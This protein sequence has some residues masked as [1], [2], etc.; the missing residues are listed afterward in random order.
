MFYRVLI[1]V[2]LSL[3]LLFA[4]SQKQAVNNNQYSQDLLF[5]PT[6]NIDS[7]LNTATRQLQA[8]E[9]KGDEL[10]KAKALS[11]IAFANKYKGQPDSA[12][13][14]Y[15][16]A[17]SIF[18]AGKNDEAAEYTDI[19]LANI[20]IGQYKIDTALSYLIGVDSL[21]KV[22]K[23]ASL[24]ADVKWNLGLVYKNKE[25]YLNAAR[26]FKMALNAFQFQKKYSKYILAG[27][28]LSMAYRL[29][30][31]NDSSLNIL[32]QCISVFNKQ[33]LSDSLLYA[34]IQENYADTYLEMGKYPQALAGFKAALAQFTKYNSTVDIA[35]QKYSIGTTLAQMN[36][37]KEAENYLLQ[38][39][40]VNDSIKN[41]KYL[42]WISNALNHMYAEMGDWRNAY[43]YLQKKA[44]WTDTIG[45]NDQIEKV[46]A[47]NRKFETK[48]KEQEIVLLKSQN[49]ITRWWY[50]SSLLT[51]LITSLLV[52]IY[53]SRKKFKEQKILN[54]FATSLYNQNTVDDVF[55]DIAKNC[56]SQLNFEDCVI[57][58]YDEARNMLLQKAAFG[59]KNPDGH[60]ISN[61]LEIPV[62]KGIV[63]SVAKSLT[64]EIIKDTRKDPRYLVDDASRNAE[65]TVP[66]IIDGKLF[67]L[68]DSEHS[69]VGFFTK[70]H[71]KIL[72]KIADT[73]SKKV[74]RQFVEEDLRK[75]I[76]RDL[77]DDM[78]STLSS[79]NIISKVALQ[80]HDMADKVKN[81]LASIKDYSL[82]MM[83][84]MS[85]MVWAINPQNDNM[86]SLVSKMKE[87]AA[88]ICESR[89]IALHFET[90]DS[91]DNL[92][93]DAEKRKHLFLIFKEALNNAVK[94]SKCQHINITISQQ[95]INNIAVSIHDDG[96]GFSM[97]NHKKGN[98]LANM[99]TRAA[100]LNATINIH[101]IQG[102]GTIV[103]LVCRDV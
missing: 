91:F 54:Y 56:I 79:I 98:G 20:Y 71:L 65:I 48:K 53:H 25:D 37:F 68:I 18:L 35:Y 86:D 58:G 44:D 51:V 22:S 72:Q 23:N 41:Y 83:E 78:G 100:Q 46:N 13:L 88:E 26:Y 60:T 61:L 87:W 5:Y 76:A 97:E 67:G 73:C 36:R 29:M 12:I 17:K 4:F 27:C 70:R 8:A 99:K 43:K 80:Q 14:F 15:K 39:Y 1:T 69:R 30:D 33:S 89:E 96:V 19:A 95:G 2:V 38:A 3:S 81:Y 75:K 57:Y 28:H 16:R 92:Q 66:I 84:N 50:L 45:I 40:M 6:K 47:L 93:I 102:Q 64:P 7:L 9:Q 31:Q 49:Q 11:D 90:P 32:A 94:Y 10:A 62:G 82:N 59:P 103:E 21:S 101:A 34:T 63:G 85:D 52:W 77:H 55:W 42:V 24:Q 74:T